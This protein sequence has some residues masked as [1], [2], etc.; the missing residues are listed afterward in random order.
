MGVGAAGVVVP[1]AT[2]VILGG[3]E[4]K[5]VAVNVNGPPKEPAVIFCK[6][7]VAGL[8]VLVKVQTIFAKG[9]KLVTGTVIVLPATV[10]KLVGLPVVPELVS[11]QGRG[12][13]ATVKLLFAASVSVTGL[14]ILLTELLFTVVGAAVPAVVV[15]IFAGVPAKF[16]AV[17][18][19]GPPG[20]PVVIF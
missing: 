3:L 18:V 15:V 10:P 8:G 11:V 7:S 12:P 14:L 20:K 6:L 5:L 1:A 9:F 4:A 2:V 16:V 13:V 19:N 17:N